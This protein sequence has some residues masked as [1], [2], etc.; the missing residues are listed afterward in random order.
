MFDTHAHLNFEA[1]KDSF[2]DV[3]KK[4]RDDGVLN[5]V[6]P[7]TDF[8]TS[9]KAV[10]IATDYEGIYSAVGIHPTKELDLK[11]LETDVYKIEELANFEKVVAIGE[12][13]LDY[14]RFKSPA[15]VQKKYFEA[16]V[17]IAKKLD[18]TLIIHNRHA[19]REVVRS[20]EKFWDNSLSQRT[21]F[22]C[23]EV[24]YEMLSFAL[25]K[26][27]FIG[28]DGDVTFDK[29]KQ[30]FISEVPIN[31]LVVE[32]DSPYILPEPKRSEKAFPNT[33]S[34]LIYIIESVSTIKKLPTDEVKRITS[35][36]AKTLF[37]LN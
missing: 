22:H 31:Q 7:G 19:G 9:K 30:K 15:S 26:G 2:D 8:D 18:K 33:S 32:T 29:T 25:E 20:V 28:V 24:D 3:I 21:V 4:S 12:I 34:N 35:L 5:I 6:V 11:N 27:I 10:E 37:A 1:F 36:N 23:C 13:G 14:Y 16:Q 17:K